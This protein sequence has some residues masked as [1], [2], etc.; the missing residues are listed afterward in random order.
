ML[1]RT[2]ESEHRSFKVS[3]K[4]A[5]SQVEELRKELDELQVQYKVTAL[6]TASDH[7]GTRKR[8]S[9][10]RCPHQEAAEA[11]AGEAR[12]AA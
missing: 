3:M 7:A 11:A 12:D 1:E 10:S 4:K 5:R 2:K 9:A 6:Q 8:A